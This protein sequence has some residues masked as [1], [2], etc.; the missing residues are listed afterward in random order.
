[1]RAPGEAQSDAQPGTTLWLSPTNRAQAEVRS[2]LLDDSLGVVSVPNLFTFDQN[3][4][5]VLKA[6]LQAVT[7][8]SR[9]HAASVLPPIV[10]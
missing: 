10:N 2:H 1:M 7:P 6:A 5:E 4:D 3:T 8:C 9:R